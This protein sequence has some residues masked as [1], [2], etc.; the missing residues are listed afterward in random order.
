LYVLAAL[1]LAVTLVSL[2][3]EALAPA[4]RL[5]VPASLPVER[6]M[7]RSDAL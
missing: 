3:Q 6:K 4:A 1:L 2:R 5:P 7:R